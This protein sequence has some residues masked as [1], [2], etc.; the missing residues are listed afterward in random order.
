[1][2][3]TIL[4]LVLVF[5]AGCDAQFEPDEGGNQTSPLSMLN[6]GG[7]SPPVAHPAPVP[8]PV[9]KCTFRDRMEALMRHL[10]MC[11]Q[12]DSSIMWWMESVCPMDGLVDDIE[13]KLVTLQTCYGLEVLE[14]DGAMWYRWPSVDAWQ[15]AIDVVVSFDPDN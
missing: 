8:T 3:S 9:S 6:E 7:E 15:Y 4:A 13:R 2:R 1:M 12:R 14:A 10:S 11:W 5:A